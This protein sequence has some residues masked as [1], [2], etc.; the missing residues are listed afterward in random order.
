MR[1]L[2]F[3]SYD[4]LRL[5]LARKDY[6]K[7]K[8]WSKKSFLGKE[9]DSNMEVFD[10]LENHLVIEVYLSPKVLTEPRTGRFVDYEN[11]VEYII[12]DIRNLEAMLNNEIIDPSIDERL[13]TIKQACKVLGLSRT[14]VYKLF[15]EEKLDFY[16][17]LTQKKVKYSDLMEFIKTAKK[18]QYH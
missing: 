7:P 17:I 12:L 6:L 14:S 4:E 16:E 11:Q 15:K 1:K 5:W 8:L 18:G 9:F 3:S 10:W 2:I 13:L